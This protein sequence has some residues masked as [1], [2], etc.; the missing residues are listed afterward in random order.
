LPNAKLVLSN[1]N[2]LAALMLVFAL[3]LGSVGAWIGLFL[4][5]QG[6][7]PWLDRC[8]E[9]RA[10]WTSLAEVTVLG[11]MILLLEWMVMPKLGLLPRASSEPLTVVRLIVQSALTCSLALVFPAILVCIQRPL[12]VF[13]LKFQPFF[14]QVRDGVIGFLLALVPMVPLMLLTAPLRNH[15]NQNALLKLLADKPEPATVAVICFTAVVAAPLFEEMLF[16]VILQGWL[17]TIVKP[18]AAIL[19]TAVAFAAVHGVIDGIALLPLAGV[20]GYVFHRRH[21]YLAV[22]VIHGLF[23]ATMLTL[24]LLTQ[25]APDRPTELEEGISDQLSAIRLLKS[26]C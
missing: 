7:R 22:V 25:S 20:L 3:L 13:G 5:W 10:N 18:W 12:A 15:D 11:L 14:T 2:Q 4:S 21:S 23:N 16:R 24:A 6:D 26:D 1:P 9:P 8:D 19:V 17:A